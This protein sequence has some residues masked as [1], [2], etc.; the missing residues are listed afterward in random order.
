MKLSRAGDFTP[1]LRSVG[2]T[3]WGKA[4]LIGILY[5][6]LMRLDTWCSMSAEP[7]AAVL[8]TAGFGF[9]ATWVWGKKILP[10]IFIGGFV[11]SALSL[12]PGLS[13]LISCGNTLA[14]FVAYALIKKWKSTDALFDSPRNAILFIVAVVVGQGGI[15]A[16]IDVFGLYIKG[17]LS[18]ES[19]SSNW[20]ILFLSHATG[21]LV[22]APFCVELFRQGLKPFTKKQLLEAVFVFSALCIVCALIFVKFFSFSLLVHPEMFLLIPVL[23]CALFRLEN[24]LSF[25]ALAAGGMFAPLATFMGQNLSD[26]MVVKSLLL[27]EINLMV[28]SLTILILAPLVA[29]RGKG[30]NDL[31]LAQEMTIFALVSAAKIRSGESDHHLL[32]TQ[33]FVAVLADDLRKHPR[34]KAELRNSKRELLIKS[35]PLHDIGKVGVPDAILK[36]QAP[37]TK[38][39]FDEIK[40]H[41][42]H[43]RDALAG[44]SAMLGGNSFLRMAEDIIYTHHERWDGKGYP[45]GLKADEIPV[46]GRLMAL[47]DAYDAL[48]QYR[49]YKQCCSHENAISV[50]LKE[51]GKAFD[52]DVVDAFMRRQ[53]AFSKIKKSLPDTCLTSDRQLSA[54]PECDFKEHLNAP[55]QLNVQEKLLTA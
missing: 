11:S 40:M 9:A 1:R 10:A 20:W 47:A 41:T 23:L 38:E 29:Q 17:A 36:K 5:A 39:E 51:K 45:Q 6:L 33:R 7:L 53:E 37:L 54:W 22:V 21:T 55:E 43:G 3:T 19:I 35:A 32:R 8:P 44:A 24:R 34:F 14:I 46:A 48:T 25:A 2:D 28:L 42:V 12:A 31:Q 30:L 49:I 16:L 4:I 50:I 26:P 27:V 52:P 13:L 15:N 18:A